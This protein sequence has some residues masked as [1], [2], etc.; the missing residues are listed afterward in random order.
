MSCS[1]FFYSVSRRTRRFL[2]V[3]SLVA[4]LASVW[5]YPVMPQAAT[6]D[7]SVPFPEHVQLA[8]RGEEHADHEHDACATDEVCRLDE[9]DQDHDAEHAHGAC[10]GSHE[11]EPA[12]A[13]RACSTCAPRDSGTSIV[14][15]SAFEVRK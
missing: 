4:Y 7:H 5:G 10:C 2:T 6:H 11:H 12:D 14:W 8:L 13:H 15:V 9:G 3:V 1:R